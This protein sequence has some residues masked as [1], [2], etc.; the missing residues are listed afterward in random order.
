MI[1]KIYARA[2]QNNVV[3]EIF[4]DAFQMPEQNDI[5][6]AQG[7]GINYVHISNKYQVVDANM[8]YNYK[9][10]GNQLVERTE[11]EKINDL[12]DVIRAEKLK[13]VSTACQNTIY[14]GMDAETS[15]G[16]KHFSL[17]LEDQ[18]NLSHAYESV[19]AGVEVFP[20][21]ADGELCSMYTKDD[22]EKISEAATKFKLYHATYCNH[23]NV[24]IR[25]ATTV[26]EIEKIQYGMILPNDLLENF[27]S[28]IGGK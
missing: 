23:L 3:T 28:I 20:Y 13:E 21:H 15:K 16:I 5:C 11:I 6:V 22:I 24:L 12:I 27:N 8:R 1:H 25:R 17:T 19:K 26:D 10:V 9:L 7:S 2:N 18:T 4:S 14:G